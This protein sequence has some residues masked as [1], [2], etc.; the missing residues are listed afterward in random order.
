MPARS[1]IIWSILGGFL[2]LPVGTG[3]DAPGIP[4]MDKTAIAGISVLIWGMIFARHKVFVLPR[5]KILV[6]LMV[7]YIFAPLA[8]MLNNQ[9]PLRLSVSSLPGMTTYDGISLVLIQM[10]NLIPFL[11][12]YSSFKTAGDMQKLLKA[13]VVAALVYSVLI[14]WEVRMSP[15]LHTQLYGFFPHSF[16]QQMR[17]G[18]FR[19]VVFL[20]HGLVVAIFVAMATVAAIGL[21]RSRIKVLGLPGI[22][23]T[24]FLLVVLILCK[25]LGA[26]ILAILIGLALYLLSY[27]TVITILAIMG[28]IIVSYPLMRG[29]GLIPVNEIAEVSAEFSSDRAV[30]FQTRVD[31]EEM[32]L[33]KAAQ[34]PFFG[35]GNWGRGRI[36]QRD[37]S[38]KFDNDISITDGT[39][40]III[41]TFGWVGYLATFGLLAYPTARA[42][43]RRK[44]FAQAPGYVALLA[45]LIIN[46]LDL[47]PNSSLTPVTWFVSGVLAGFM[48]HASKMSEPVFR[49]STF[50]AKAETQAN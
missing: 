1:A 7:L 4:N 44:Q 25:S 16:S 43:R 40:I 28:L 33:E 39:W 12:G 20:G 34:K 49:H 30:S 24:M 35:W 31:N 19:A 46:L 41:S 38:G 5:S 36:Y 37:W 17:A 14:L 13:L 29:V 11:I 21:W 32:L 6:G 22:A 48:P 9:D 10:I 8:T 2:L 42:F 47:L 27:R 3:F 18:G 26:I 23:Y 50:V 45:I 15:Q